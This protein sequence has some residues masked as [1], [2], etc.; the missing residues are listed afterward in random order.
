MIPPEFFTF[1]HQEEEEA[2]RWLA[3]EV[4]AHW[5]ILDAESA[6]EGL[7]NALALRPLLHRPAALAW[8]GLGPGGARLHQRL[9]ERHP[10]WRIT[11]FLDDPAVGNAPDALARLPH[12]APDG[13]ILTHDAPRWRDKL[14]DAGLPTEKIFAPFQD[15]AVEQ[16]AHA[17]RQAEAERFAQSLDAAAGSPLLLFVVAQRGNAPTVEFLVETLRAAHPEWRLAAL[18]LINEPPPGLYHHALFCHGSLQVM[19]RVLH[20]V[21]PCRI[22]VQGHF[23]WLFL[24]QMV[25]ALRPDL[26]VIHEVYDWFSAFLEHPEEALAEGLWPRG[27]VQALM[28]SERFILDH[29]QGVI[30]KDGSP[31]LDRLLGSARAPSARLLPSPPRR[32]MLPPRESPAPKKSRLVYAGRVNPSTVSPA[33][34]GDSI[35]LPLMA[36]LVEQGFPVTLFN[37]PMFPAPHIRLLY[38]DYHQLAREN[39]LFRFAQGMPFEPLLSVMREGF[40]FGLMLFNFQPGLRVGRA[41]LQGTMA[42]K[43]FT[44]LA[45]GLPVLASVENSAMARLVEQHGLGAALT[46]DDIPRLDALLGHHDPDALRQNVRRAQQSLCFEENCREAIRLLIG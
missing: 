24:S 29:L 17:R 34:F 30:V 45:A 36:Q 43:L 44:Y 14:L 11:R 3:S 38:D 46:M 33:F 5:A 25:K 2:R 20:R 15:P 12:E 6:A 8:Q 27:A 37:S 32:M 23:R 16:A 39:P 28:A 26:P 18:Y 31:H 22:Y 10:Q 1:P 9:L 7:E 13:V 41:H 4:R 40:D 35:I 21:P 19:S 42:S